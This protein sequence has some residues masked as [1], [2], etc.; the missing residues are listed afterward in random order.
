MERQTW[1]LQA[2]SYAAGSSC[3]AATYIHPDTLKV[4]GAIADSVETTTEPMPIGLSAAACFRYLSRWASEHDCVDE[5]GAPFRAFLRAVRYINE[6]L[7]SISL[8]ME[9]WEKVYRARTSQDSING[10]DIY[11]CLKLVSG[12]KMLRTAR[13]CIGIGPSGARRGDLVCAFLGCKSL[14]LIRPSSGEGDD[15]SYRVIGECYVEALDDAVTLLGPLP[16][17]WS[18]RID[19]IKSGH[20]T[21]HRFQE[22]E[23]GPGDRGGP[24]SGASGRRVGKGPTGADGR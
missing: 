3:S 5:N 20:G 19:E 21:T 1:P 7:P 18:V 23:H 9:D 15:G 4:T 2:F 17:G 10:G 12:R 6:R 22:R 16:T 8:S 14:V 24:A 13:G 11:W